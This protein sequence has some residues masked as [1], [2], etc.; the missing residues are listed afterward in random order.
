VYIFR[1]KA[2]FYS[3][4]LLA[5]RPTPKLEDHLVS[6]V[7]DCLFNILAATLHIGGRS[8][9]CNLR[10]RHAVVTGTHLSWNIDC[11]E[12]VIL[13]STIQYQ[14]GVHNIASCSRT[15]NSRMETVRY[16][17]NKSYSMLNLRNIIVCYVYQKCT[18][19]GTNR[20]Y[21]VSH[22][23]HPNVL[24]A[25]CHPQGVTNAKV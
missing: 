2:S 17:I 22:R 3:E 11:L 5:S 15:N 19:E 14:H 8:S 16:I 9:I 20:T 6:A 4:V 25:R 18:Q 23:K 10:T 1:N 21:H 24:A 13:N 12:D 7:R